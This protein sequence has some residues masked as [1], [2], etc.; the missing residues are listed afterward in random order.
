[1]I[2][3]LIIIEGCFGKTTNVSL[4]KLYRKLL[5]LNSMD[6]LWSF[7]RKYF[8][9]KPILQPDAGCFCLKCQAL[10]IR[11]TVTI[12]KKKLFKNVIGCFSKAPFNCITRVQLKNWCMLRLDKSLLLLGV[13]TETLHF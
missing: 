12:D 5:K 7:S 4:I 13:S 10:I 1:M 9:F 2:N 3:M 8:Y 6:G 11:N